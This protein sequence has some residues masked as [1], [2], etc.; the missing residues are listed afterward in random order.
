MGD[1]F[2]YRLGDRVQKIEGYK[3]IG[4]ILA[5]YTT[6]SGIR[7]DVQVTGIDQLKDLHAIL[8]N[9]GAINKVKDL[10]KL[11]ELVQN[12]AGMIHIF[13]EKQIEKIK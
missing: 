12:C 11:V 13:S 9:T 5:R 2:K 3:F 8:K 7:Y 10:E 4:R 6:N 1:S